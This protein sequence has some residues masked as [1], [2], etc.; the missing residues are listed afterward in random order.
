MECSFCKSFVDFSEPLFHQDYRLEDKLDRYS[1]RF[2]SSTNNTREAGKKLHNC[3]MGWGSWGPPVVV[4]SVGQ[5]IVAAVE[6]EKYS[7]HEI[8]QVKL[9]RNKSI[10]DNYEL[11]LVFEEWRSKHKIDFSPYVDETETDEYFATLPGESVYDLFRR[12]YAQDEKP[13]DRVEEYYIRLYNKLEEF[14]EAI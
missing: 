12:E 7:P 13:V 4:I 3:L 2:L 5:Q 1:F 8:R 6:L 11:L 10:T 14:E 9:K